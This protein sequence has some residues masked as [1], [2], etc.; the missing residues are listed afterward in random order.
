M[1]LGSAG[2]MAEAELAALP[3]DDYLDRFHL[4]PYLQDALALVLVHRP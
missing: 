1:P 4:R 2:S 3:A